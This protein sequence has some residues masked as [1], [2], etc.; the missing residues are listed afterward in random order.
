MAGVHG[1]IAVAARRLAKMEHDFGRMQ[2]QPGD[3]YPAFD[4]F[5]AAVVGL[6]VVVIRWVAG[7]V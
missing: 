5:V 3:P 6:S 1:P 2:R 4:F 7:G